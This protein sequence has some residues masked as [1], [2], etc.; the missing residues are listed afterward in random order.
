[1][2]QKG[3]IIHK[4]HKHN[5]TIDI[6]ATIMSKNGSRKGLKGEKVSISVDC[7]GNLVNFKWYSCKL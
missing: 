5:N 4:I 7:N 1:M 6:E 2:V 3:V